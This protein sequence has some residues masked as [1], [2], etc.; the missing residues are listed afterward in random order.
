[1]ESTIV[2]IIS[3]Q[4][5]ETKGTVTNDLDPTGPE[6]INVD[7]LTD[8]QN[9]ALMGFDKRLFNFLTRLVEKQ[10]KVCMISILPLFVI[11]H[12]VLLKSHSLKKHKFHYPSRYR[13][14]PFINLS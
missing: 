4:S 11:N 10:L 8:T 14:H 3:S 13:R 9:I 2:E 5:F 12:T 7:C 6:A 1:M